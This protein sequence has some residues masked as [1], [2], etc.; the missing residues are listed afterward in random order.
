MRKLLL[1]SMAVLIMNVLPAQRTIIHCGQLIDVKNLQVLK[2]MS[3]IID[4]NKIS[5]VQKGYTAA[6]A[7]DKLIDLKNKT[8]MPGLIDMHVHME[9]ETG[10]NK[11]LNGF[12]WNPSDYAFQSVVFAE[13]TLLAGFTTV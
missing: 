4:G 2:E 6:A 5:D 8:V 10:P 11:Y 9:D 1:F 12:T 3:V 13:R 7:G